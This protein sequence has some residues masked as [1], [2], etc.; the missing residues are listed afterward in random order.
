MTGTLATGFEVDGE[1][2]GFYHFTGFD[3]GAHRIMAIKNA[4]ASPAVQELINWYEA[5]IATADRD[6]IS[7]WPW[8]FGRF[9]DGTP[10]EIGH[11]RVYRDHEDLQRAFPDPYDARADRMSYID[12]CR[13]EGRIRYP[14][15]FAEGG[16]RRA[17]KPARL[18]TRV[19]LPTALRL[20]GL[21]LSPRSGKALRERCRRV[22]RREGLAGFARRIHGPRG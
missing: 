22:F 2:L 8:A 1:P 6:P 18:D 21:M 13:T 9:S 20:F 14:D 16:A 11:R 10:I 17:P 5:E 19:S 3:S 12:W 7:E 4:P 15:V